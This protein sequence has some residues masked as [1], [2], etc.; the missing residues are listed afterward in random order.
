MVAS[1]EYI[2]QRI[3]YFTKAA[4]LNLQTPG[5]EGNIVVLTPEIADEVL[6]AG[7]IHGNRRNFLAI[8]KLADLENN[9]R[10]HLVI[11]EVCHGGPTY[12]A[13]GGC[14]SHGLLEEC[15]KLKTEFPNQVH[16]ILSNHELAELTEYPI[17]KS[18]QMLNLLFQLGLQQMYGPVAVKIREAFNPFIQSCPFAVKTAGGAFI[19]HS[20]PENVD[21][22][23]FDVSFLRRE[24]DL[25]EMSLRT[26]LFEMLWGRDFRQENAEAFLELVGAEVLITGHEPC[27]D[28]FA[29]PNSRQVIIDCCEENARCVLIPVNG[30]LTQED[31]LRCVKA[32]R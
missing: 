15:A 11:Q 14:M 8:K 24:V 5:R 4:E 13:N 19:S 6:I 9:P 31:V 32:L 21:S 3:E 23:N 1:F 2:D 29:V 18:G 17:Q 10:R 7:D 25:A 28:G 16:V 20:I 22:R 26:G 12:P 27:P 30:Q